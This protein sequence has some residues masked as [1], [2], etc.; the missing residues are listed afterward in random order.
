MELRHL[1]YFVAVAEELHY[2][3]A[4][5]RLHISQ[6][7]L[8]VQISALEQE[9]GLKLFKRLGRTIELTAAGH[10]FLEHSRR[11]LK[12]VELAVR[13]AERVNRGA[14]GEISVGFLSALAYSYLPWLLREF[15]K[16]YPDVNLILHEMT[17]QQQLDALLEARLQVGLLRPPVN[18]P[19]LSSEVVL[20]EPYV[21]ALNET[22]PFAAG[23]SI[24]METLKDERF[25]MNSRRMGGRYLAQVMSMCHDAGF[26]PNVAQEAQQLHTTVGLVSAGL[27][28]AIVPASIQVLQ[29]EGVVYRPLSG[30]LPSSQV[31]M[32]WRRDETSPAVRAFSDLVREIVPLGLDALRRSTAG[33]VQPVS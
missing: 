12:Q 28:I 18:S 1:R 11:L 17:V 31:T 29:M 7:P 13:S 25:I 22:H 5:K 27:G 33:L 3:K 6:P 16:R 4:A 2:G 23:D 10:E 26:T 8:S 19:E 32:A 9:L 21:V 24:A 14:I 30:T 20:R 15:G